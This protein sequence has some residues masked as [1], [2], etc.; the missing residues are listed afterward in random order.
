[1]TLMEA[2]GAGEGG[3]NLLSKTATQSD[4]LFAGPLSL[5]SLREKGHFERGTVEL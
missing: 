5:A 2:N 1:M 4:V 3:E